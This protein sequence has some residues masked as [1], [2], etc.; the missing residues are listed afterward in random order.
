MIHCGYSSSSSLVIPTTYQTPVP[1]VPHGKAHSVS[2]RGEHRERPQQTPGTH[3]L[4][5]VGAHGA[6]VESFRVERTAGK[7]HRPGVLQRGDVAVEQAGVHVEHTEQ[8][9]NDC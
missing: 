5:V 8:V 4:L 7:A 9:E 3:D 2:E 6:Q 1:R